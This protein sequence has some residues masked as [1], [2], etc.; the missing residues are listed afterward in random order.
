MPIHSRVWS[1]CK[2]LKDLNKNRVRE[3]GDFFSAYN[4]V[5][6]KKFKIISVRGPKRAE[7]LAT[8]GMKKYKK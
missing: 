6:G 4:R 8:Q 1:N 5:R 3:I 2:S 7:A